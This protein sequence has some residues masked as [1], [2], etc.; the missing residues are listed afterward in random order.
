MLNAG[1]KVKTN[2]RLQDAAPSL[3]PGIATRGVSAPGKPGSREEALKL[4]QHLFLQCTESESPRTVTFAG[5]DSEEGSRR[6]AYYAAEILADSIPGSVCL[7]DT[8]LEAPQL[9]RVHS[10]RRRRVRR[11]GGRHPESERE[12]LPEDPPVRPGAQRLGPRN[13]WLLPCKSCALRPRLDSIRVKTWVLQL[14]AEF[15]YVLFNAPPVIGDGMAGILGAISDGLVLSIE[16]GSTRREVACKAKEIL[17]LANVRLLG[18]VLNNRPFPI[19]E[20]VYRWL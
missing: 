19:P 7:V 14:R 12:L 18:A 17:E 8:A 2:P 10:E 4:V 9:A 6:V 16:A 5:V 20:S 1:L 13:L 3:Q 15:D 11:A